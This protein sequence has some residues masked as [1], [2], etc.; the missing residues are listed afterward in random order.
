MPPPLPQP[1]LS[2]RARALTSALTFKIVS[3]TDTAI[4]V[5]LPLLNADVD[6]A[7]ATSLVVAVI[8]CRPRHLEMI[9]VFTTTLL[10]ALALP[11]PSCCLLLLPLNTTAQEPSSITVRWPC[12]I[13]VCINVNLLLFELNSAIIN[14]KS[15]PTEE[16]SLGCGLDCKAQSCIRHKAGNN[17]EHLLVIWLQTEAMGKVKAM[18]IARIERKSEGLGVRDESKVLS[19]VVQNGL[20]TG[21][22]PKEKQAKLEHCFVRLLG[23]PERF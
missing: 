13:D 17:E 10:V 12:P 20:T 23:D 19:D 5:L 14:C 6:A 18:A 3:A 7:V 11:P 1:L 9:V 2:A 4:A 22:H 8:H 15:M 16:L 21:R